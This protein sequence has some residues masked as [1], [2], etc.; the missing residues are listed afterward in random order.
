M[1]T[2]ARQLSKGNRQNYEQRENRKV[3]RNRPTD[4]L[5]VGRTRRSENRHLQPQC[6][7]STHKAI[8]KRKTAAP[9]VTTS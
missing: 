9:M 7:D 5:A 4:A 1:D 3:A 6:R 8:W 2:M